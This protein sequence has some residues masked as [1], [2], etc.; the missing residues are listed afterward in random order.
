ML[1]LALPKYVANNVFGRVSS[2]IVNPVSNT[3]SSNFFKNIQ[4]AIETCA[5][6]FYSKTKLILRNTM[7]KF[8]FGSDCVRSSAA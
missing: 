8:T 6:H 5:S 7:V 2:T 4:F 1:F 3:Y